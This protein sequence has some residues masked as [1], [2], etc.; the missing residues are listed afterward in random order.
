MIEVEATPQDTT[1]YFNSDEAWHRVCET[2]DNVLRRI[3]QKIS[4][5]DEA[6]QD[7]CMSEARMAI[8][9]IR[10]SEVRGYDE[11]R[12][13]PVSV[14]NIP[15]AVDRFIRNAARNSMLSYM[16]SWQTGNFY[17][18]RSYTVYAK[19][20]SKRKVHKPAR[21]ASIVDLQLDGFDID[22]N[23]RVVGTVDDESY[24]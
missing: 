23:G 21:Y 17:V 15:P 19:D 13:G 10:P 20:G 2:Y 6:L 16:Q 18:G 1:S 22:Q 3:A 14:D 7:D 4:T 8:Y 5:L 24:E 11:A 9:G 12:D